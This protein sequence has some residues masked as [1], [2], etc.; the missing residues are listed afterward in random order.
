M[1][2]EGIFT[3]D[4]FNTVRG[5]LNVEGKATKFITAGINL[6]FADRNES[7]IPA[8]WARVITNTPYGSKYN[9]DGTLKWSPDSDEGVLLTANAKNPFLAMEYTDR[10][11]IT[12]TLL[13]NIYL[14]GDLP[15]G[16][17]YQINYAPRYTFDK[18]FDANSSLNQ[19]YSV[20]GGTAYRNHREVFNWQIDNIIQWNKTFNDIH[21]LDLTLLANAEKYQSWSSN[22]NNEGFQPND[23]L[24]YHNIGSGTNPGVSSNDEYST[25]DALMARLN[26]ALKNKYLLTT[27]IRRDG[28]SAF[29]QKNPRATFPS[30]ALGW[31]LSEEKLLESLKWLDFAKLRL[32]Y[33]INGNRDIGR[34]LAL[35]DLSS[36]KYLYASSSTG[37][38]YIVT[39]LFVNRM[40]NANLSWEE[41]TAYN[42]GLDLNILYNRISGSIDLYSKSTHNLL[43]RRSLPNITGFTSVMDNLGEISNK[44]LELRLNTINVEHKNI[45]WNSLLNFSVN[46]N[47]IIHLYGPVNI[48]NDDGNVIGQHEPDDPSNGWFI[49]HAIDEIWDLKVLGVWQENEKDEANKYGVRPGDFKL[50]DVDGDNLYT[51]EDRQFLGYRSPKFQWS[52]RNEFNIYKNIDFSFMLY[53]NWGQMKTFNWAKNSY[54]GTGNFPERS[55]NYQFPYWTPENQINDFAA[56]N[57]SSGG[58]TYNI[59]RDASFI[60]LRNIVIAYNFPEKLVNR[61]HL[62][63]LKLSFNIN[64]VAFYAPTWEF[65][66][67]ENNGPTPRT[68]TLGINLTF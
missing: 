50:E 32:S 43:V 36:G 54:D 56:N 49:G 51:D 8:N 62:E 67:P 68:F 58:A 15:Y 65:W 17:S 45:S 34:Y 2:N 55:S 22:I 21:R 41:T 3:G 26:Y 53:S 42:I 60:R 23:D 39:E 33:G 10:L 66:D 52:L 64:N 35:S 1:D 63:N 61:A 38:P 12:R 44:G 24:S 28:Y 46:R 14:K 19:D 16:F 57:S 47:K 40:S 25:G 20:I 4:K 5:R 7:S 27:S 18:T 9:D 48:L 11:F 30:I 37:V 29:G 13:S 6:Q 31:I 59:Y